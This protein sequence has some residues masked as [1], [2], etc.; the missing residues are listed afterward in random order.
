MS[1][2]QAKGIE[3][4]E[5]TDIYAF[6][7]IL[8]EVLTHHNIVWGK[9]KEDVLKKIIAGTTQTP[10]QKAPNRNIPRELDAICMKCIALDPEE[11]YQSLL[12]VAEELRRYLHREPLSSYHY[13]PIE[14]IWIWRRQ[15]VMS[16]TSLLFFLLGM[17]FAWLIIAS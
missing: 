6:G 14:R 5:R 12:E 3:I 8:Y 15:H 9:D 11:R 7:A 10:R 2:E 4:D 1:P 13:N 16:T 17:L